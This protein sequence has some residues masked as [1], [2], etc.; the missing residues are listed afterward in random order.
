MASDGSAFPL[1][2]EG[3]EHLWEKSPLPLWEEATC[4]CGITGTSVLGTGFSASTLVFY[5]GC[6]LAGATGH[7]CH[8]VLAYVY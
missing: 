8:E 2:R 4:S 3:V 7:H 6:P 5:C 1:E